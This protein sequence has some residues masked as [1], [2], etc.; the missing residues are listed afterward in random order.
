MIS[1]DAVHYGDEDWGGRNFARF[2]ADS[3]GYE[4]AIALEK[5]IVDTCINGA[6]EKEKVKKFCQY[7]VKKEDYRDYLWSWCGRYSVPM[8][9]LTGYYLAENLKMSLSGIPLDYSTSISNAHIKVNDLK[10]GTTAPSKLRHWVG[11]ASVGF[12]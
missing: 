4:K 11:Y 2:G 5:E 9:L 8:G 6:L 1:T 7:T 12:R 3:A 10:M